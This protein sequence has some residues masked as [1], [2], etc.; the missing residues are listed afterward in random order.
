MHRLIKFDSLPST[1]TY[2]AGKLAEGV[3][4]ESPTTVVAKEQPSGRGQKGNTWFT[5][6]KCNITLTTYF[7]PHELHP[8]DQFSIC[9]L[10]ALCS[11]Y[12]LRDW[13]PEVG[14][15]KLKWPN[16]IYY[17]DCKLGGIL[18]EHSVTGPYIDHTLIGIGIN[19][20]E[21]IFPSDLPNPISLRML[22]GETYCIDDL[23][24]QYMTVF[25]D[26]SKLLNSHNGRDQ[27]HQEYL[28]LLYRKNE[29]H[30]FVSEAVE[31]EGEI[32]DVLPGGLLCLRH[33]TGAVKEYA[34]K[35]ISFV[36]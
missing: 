31:F 30:R 33:S 13:V 20:N 4:I 25:D 21:Q 32:V 3:A 17:G 2:V 18:I 10:A 23:I 7:R 35:E 34:F 14:K 9:E 26:L 16:D 36:I 5:P 11:V 15:L 22:T 27:L 24:A 19:I 6:P 12:L 28:M 1:N 8:E 29:V